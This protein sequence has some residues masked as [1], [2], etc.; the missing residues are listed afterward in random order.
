MMINL[1]QINVTIAEMKS[2]F[3]AGHTMPIESRKKMLKELYSTIES[4]SDDICQAVFKDFHKSKEEMLVTEI[5]PVLSEIK[6]T[7]AHINAWSKPKNVLS[8][9]L[10]QPSSSKIYKTPKGLVLIFAPWNYSFYLSLMPFVSAIAAGNVVLLKPA[11]ETANVSDV[12]RRII[13]KVFDKNV[14]NVILGDGKEIAEMLFSHFRFDHV[15]FTGSTQAGSWIAQKCSE[16]LTPFTLELGGKSPAVVDKQ[17]NLDVAAKRI[18]WGK[19]LNAGQTCVCPDY[20]LVHKDVESEFISLCKK[21][22]V[23][24]FGN[25]TLESESY[26]HIINAQRFDRI[27]TYLKD[28]EIVQ[29]GKYDKATLCIEPTII[30]VNDL[31]TSVM[32]EEIFGPVLPIVTYENYN[33]ALSII[34]QN[35]NPLSFYVFTKNNDFAEK[36]FLNVEFGGGCSNNVIIHL[37]N[38]GLPFGGVQQSGMGSYHGKWGFDTF[39]NTKPVVHFAKWF[40]ISLHYHPYTKNKLSLI[41]RFFG[42]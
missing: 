19:Y 29:G 20:V 17:V 2:Y 9:L 42:L 3:D 34:R 21:H 15:F 7:I 23:E 33:E 11:H 41:K 4:H 22:I 25:N 16:K 28:G 36:L 14:A 13:D 40:D 5:Y 18:V 39:S 24:L 30:K 31:N 35:R 6:H 32:K 37:G 38:P 8:N 26:T 27:V 10:I 1:E 12:I